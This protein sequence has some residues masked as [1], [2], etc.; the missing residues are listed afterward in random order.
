MSLPKTEL[1]T[2]AAGEQIDPSSAPTAE[3]APS[4]ELALIA[5]AVLE[6][7]AELDKTVSQLRELCVA[8]CCNQAPA[9]PGPAALIEEFEAQLI[10][11]LA[12]E[13]AEEF[14][15]SL[16][17]D[18]PSLLQRVE[19]LQAE[20]GEM[21]ETLDQLLEF[22]KSGPSWPELAVRLIRFLDG[23]DAHEHAE[24]ALMQEFFLLD[25]GGSG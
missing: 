11:H 3:S 18:Q 1:V 23:F 25:Q 16:V 5:E 15:G 22:A 7:H 10:L 12:A 24:N 9:D 2:K 21:A 6:D 19:R 20:H 17:T 8:L 14:F 13:E 4:N